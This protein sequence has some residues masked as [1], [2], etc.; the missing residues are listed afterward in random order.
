MQQDFLNDQFASITVCDKQANVIYQ[1]ERSIG[2][3]SHVVGKSLFECHPPHAAEKIQKMLQDGIPNAYTI[4]KNGKKKLIYQTPWKDTDGNIA[5]LVEYSF[6]IPFD[7]P[8][9]VRKG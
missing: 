9:Y 2:T 1:N 8:H 6:E 4:E 7:M 3:F 5:G